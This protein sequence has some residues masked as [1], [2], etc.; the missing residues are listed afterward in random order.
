MNF[1]SRETY[2]IA[3]QEW[4]DKYKSLSE[5]IREAKEARRE[6][7]RAFA[8][9]DFKYSSSY[10][11]FS[12]QSKSVRDA[13]MAGVRPVASAHLKLLNLRREAFVMLN[14]LENAKRKA[15]QQYAA[16]HTKT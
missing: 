7:E 6:A 15:Q 10:Y 8:K 4:K 1:T 5:N 2:L 13:H 16:E 9:V 3:R 11:V 12:Q 14:T